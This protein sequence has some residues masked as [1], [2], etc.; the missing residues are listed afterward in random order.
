[1]NDNLSPLLSVVIPTLNETKSGVFPLVLEPY[2]GLQNIELIVCDGGSEDSTLEMAQRAGAK[3]VTG[4]FPSRAERINAGVKA[5][6]AEMVLINHPRSRLDVLGI[7]YLIANRGKLKWGGF[8]HA[9]DNE[10]FLL[11][12]TSWYSNK[13]RAMKRNIV[14][15]DHCKFARRELLEQAL[16]LPH[17][18]IFEDTILSKALFKAA[19][20]PEILPFKSTTSAIRF[21]KNGVFKQA[22]INQWLKIRFHLGG[23][24]KKMNR[25]YEKKLDFNSPKK[26]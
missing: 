3:L 9:F 17:F 24:H 11:K 26:D 14:Y 10:H 25:L 20:G 13:T 21:T 23:D 5:S 15:L 2:I 8:T 1:M 12:F 18:E 7:A 4:D 22:L 6:A 16:P 19:G